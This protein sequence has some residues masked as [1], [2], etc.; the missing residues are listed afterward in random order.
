MIPAL[1]DDLG[2]KTDVER[3]EEFG[4]HA[5]NFMRHLKQEFAHFLWPR[6]LALLEKLL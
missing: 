2:Y 1:I 6:P 3:Q 5:C 4:L